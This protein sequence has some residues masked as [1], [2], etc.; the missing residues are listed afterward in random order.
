MKTHR[1]STTACSAGAALAGAGALWCWYAGGRPEVRTALLL[2]S[3]AGLTAAA[4][5]AAR[6]RARL[7]RAHRL[8][9]R[10][11][12][13]PAPRVAPLAPCCPFWLTTDAS[14]HH[15]DC[16][17]AQGPAGE[18]ARGWQE[19]DEA[20]CLRGWESRGAVH[21]PRTCVRTAAA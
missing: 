15:P 3:A 4:V 14:G 19:L 18:A 10:L 21:D 13:G 17:R 7:V 9:G 6:D 8:A 11:A 1:R 2:S 5:L 16:V 12:L 20:C